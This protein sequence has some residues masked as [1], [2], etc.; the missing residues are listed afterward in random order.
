MKSED[1][2]IGMS[3]AIIAN[4]KGDKFDC[5]VGTIAKITDIL[6]WGRIALELCDGIKESYW[7]ISEIEPYKK[8]EELNYTQQVAKMLG[9]EVGEK[10]NVIY[11]R[12]N[13]RYNDVRFDKDFGLYKDFALDNCGDMLNALVAGYA[14]IEKITPYAKPTKVKLGS[15]YYYVN[16]DGIVKSNYNQGATF[17]Y[18][19]YALGNMFD[20][21]KIPQQQIDEMV[22]KLKGDEA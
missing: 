14:K 8:E 4:G 17:D 16:H 1:A 3:V 7:R 15:N 9:V 21:E 19:M 22:K 13:K 5:Y 12:E 11:P 2:K 18:A 10:F 20:T 6:G